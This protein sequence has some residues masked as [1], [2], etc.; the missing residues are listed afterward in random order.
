[1]FVNIKD[2][3]SESDLEKVL[4]EHL[5]NFLLELGD[6]FAFSAQQCKQRID[7]YCFKN[8]FYFFH[9]RLKCLI[10]IEILLIIV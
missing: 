3:S 5:T 2:Q 4:I 1:M 10:L 6:D 7:D 9:R 8:K